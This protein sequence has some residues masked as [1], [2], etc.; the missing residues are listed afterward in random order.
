MK[1]MSFLSTNSK[2]ALVSQQRPRELLN[3]DLGFYR[4]DVFADAKLA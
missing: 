2:I 4:P 1:Q 3:A